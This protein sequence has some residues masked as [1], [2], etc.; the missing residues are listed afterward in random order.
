MPAGSDPVNVPA[1]T[2]VVVEDFGGRAT[3]PAEAA[4]SL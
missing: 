2:E 3:I 4:A 1:H